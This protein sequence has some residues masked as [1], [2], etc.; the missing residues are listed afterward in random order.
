L[1]VLFSDQQP[2]PGQ[3]LIKNK[4]AKATS[5]FICRRCWSYFLTNNFVQVKP[6]SK[7]K[8][9]KPHHFSSAAV[10]GLIF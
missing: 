5:L 9:R 2:H 10:V 4:R 6:S 3:T 1:L 8:E 7:T